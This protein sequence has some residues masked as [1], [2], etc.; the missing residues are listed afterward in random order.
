MM[1]E[2]LCGQTAMDRS[3]EEDALLMEIRSNSEG[4]HCQSWD[5]VSNE[6]KMDHVG[7]QLEYNSGYWFASPC[8][9]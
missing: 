7:F 4:S 5:H 6:V 3:E 9:C 1:T 2:H 8:Q